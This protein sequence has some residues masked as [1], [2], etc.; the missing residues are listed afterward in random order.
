VHDRDTA[1]AAVAGTIA[2]M[3]I[4]EVVTAITVPL[5]CIDPT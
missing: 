3:Q 1:S 2:A 5:H 4:Y